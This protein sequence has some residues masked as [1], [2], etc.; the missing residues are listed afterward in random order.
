MLSD[1]I[2]FHPMTSTSKG[3]REAKIISPRYDLNHSEVPDQM[4]KVFNDYFIHVVQLCITF[5]MLI[6][7]LVWI[8]STFVRTFVLGL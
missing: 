4:H 7:D 5:L 1:V 2:V 8:C 6:S 3:T